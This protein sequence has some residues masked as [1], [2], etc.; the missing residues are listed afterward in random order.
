MEHTTSKDTTDHRLSDNELAE[1]S[2]GSRPF[3]GASHYYPYGWA[4]TIEVSGGTLSER[5]ARASASRLS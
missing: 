5:T 2:G 1:I 4:E 3:N